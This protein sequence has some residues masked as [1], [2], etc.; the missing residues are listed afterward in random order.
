MSSLHFALWAFVFSVGSYIPYWI[1]II[2]QGVRPQ[3]ATW[4]IWTMS[5][6]IIFGAMYSQGYFATQMLAYVIGA[7]T[8]MTYA[9]FRGT[10]GWTFEDKVVLAGAGAA[11]IG[12][13]FSSANAALV[14][15]LTATC[16]G[17]WPTI[18]N[19]AEHPGSEPRIAWTM[20][21]IGGICGLLAI[22]P[23]T[24]WNIASALGPAVFF[25]IQTIIFF[26]SWRPNHAEARV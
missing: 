26:L 20:I 9:L 12:W 14:L 21:W 11:L 24:K 18:R 22:V 15:I 3:K 1:G 4:I 2:F 17:T 19:L 13:F 6:S 23:L 7:A 8:I 5:D 10:P 16:I 25:A